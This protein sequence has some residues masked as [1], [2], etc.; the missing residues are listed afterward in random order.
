ML[1]T[2][3]GE[4]VFPIG[5]GTWTINKSNSNEN[6]T[7]IKY[8]LLRGGNLIE[9]NYHYDNWESVEVCAEA[10]KE[11]DRSQ[12][13]IVVAMMGNYN[14]NKCEEDIETA[15]DMYLEKLGTDYVDCISWGT[16]IDNLKDPTNYFKTVK[17][18]KKQGKTRF[19]G[20]SNITCEDYKKYGPFDYFEGLYNFECRINQDNGL[21][22]IAKN[23]F[24]YQPL[25]RNRT[26]QMNYPLL[27]ELSNKYGKT[28][29]QIILNWI[30]KNKQIN[31]LLKATDKKHIDENF[32]SI[33]FEMDRNDYDAMDNFRSEFFDNLQVVFHTPTEEEKS[34]GK[35]VIHQVPNQNPI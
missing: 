26:S 19:I 23:F 32:E 2:K 27:L 22:E 16:T 17:K 6:I 20:I 11:I 31:V 35:V 33:E 24:A 4:S 28:Q 10:I 13:F 14:N 29:N 5:I 25:R 15:L 7:A 18:L 9:L 8:N 34:Q 12:I 21:L 30:I 3:S 1:T